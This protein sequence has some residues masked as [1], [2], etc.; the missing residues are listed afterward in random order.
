[1]DVGNNLANQMRSVQLN[2]N[3]NAGNNETADQLAAGVSAMNLGAGS[4]LA[5]MALCCQEMD[6]PN[7]E[8]ALAGVTK[9]R[10][11]LSAESQPPIDEAIKSG[12]L[13]KL[14][15]HVQS[16]SEAL[17][18][19]SL[20]ALTNIMSGTTHHVDVALSHGVLEHVLRLI[21]SEVLNVRGQA[22]WALGNI[23]GDSTQKRDLCLE[24]LAAVALAEIAP[25]PGNNLEFLRNLSWTTSNL[26][27]GKPQPSLSLVEPLLPIICSAISHQDVEVC[28]DGLWSLSYLSQGVNEGI[29]MALRICP[30]PVAFLNH[31]SKTVVV[32]ALRICGNIAT[33]T[34]DQTQRILDCG[35]VAAMGNLLTNDTHKG[36]MKECVW[37]LSN[38]LAGTVLQI[39]HVVNANMIGPLVQLVGESPAEIRREAVWAIA[40]GL[41][42][43]SNEQA[44]TIVNNG[45]FEALCRA[46]MDSN[47]KKVIVVALEGIDNAVRKT[48]FFSAPGL[49]RSRIESIDFC[50][51]LQNLI[52]HHQFSGDS[53]IDRIATQLLNDCTAKFGG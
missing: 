7:N 50:G 44:L 40:N 37:G 28:V 10:K 4:P 27:R 3:S 24:N 1:M 17:Q 32:P 30:N 52:S 38:V 26:L 13:P 47:D 15:K 23:A 20:W 34:D 36:M 45:A 46:I 18:F 29:E 51:L 49:D 43:A 33:G 22:M 6:S 25:H 8:E 14:I 9:L 39:Q 11:L 21:K 12:A 35:W 5:A 48:N 31:T 19:E 42:G 16:D 41:T 53:N 2:G